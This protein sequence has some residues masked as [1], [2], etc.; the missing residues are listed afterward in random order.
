LKRAKRALEDLGVTYIP[1]D[2]EQRAM[3]FDADIEC[4]S[5]VTLKVTVSPQEWC[6]NT[7]DISQDQLQ[8]SMRNQSTPNS[9]TFAYDTPLTK[10]EFL[11][12]FRRL[13]IGGW[14]RSYNEKRY[15]APAACNTVWQLKIEYNNGCKP[16]KCRGSNSYPYNFKTL[17]SIFAVKLPEKIEEDEFEEVY[18]I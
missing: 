10:A 18:Y 4:I 7:I 11:H 16:Y 17:A 13:E 3:K 9:E 2:I 12:E 8:F 6:E 15:K 14:R 1:T 5:K